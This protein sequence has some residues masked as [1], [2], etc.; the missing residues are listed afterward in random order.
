M[1][2]PKPCGPSCVLA[3]KIHLLPLSASARPDGAWIHEGV[4]VRQISTQAHE[5]SHPFALVGDEGSA[6]VRAELLDRLMQDP[7]AHVVPV[8]EVCRC[9]FSMP[10]LE[11]TP[12]QELGLGFDQDRLVHP[13]ARRVDWPA[14]TLH[15]LLAEL[16]RGL[17]E[18]R[19]SGI[20]HGDPAW[21]NAFASLG[22]D[23]VHRGLWVD[24]NSMRPG[25]P[26][27]SD[28]DVAA[29]LLT[30]LVPALLDAR[31]HSPSLFADL[32]AASRNGVDVLESVIEALEKERRDL[33]A[34]GARASLGRALAEHGSASDRQDGVGRAH[35][36]ISAHLASQVLLD[37]TRSDQNARFFRAVLT[38]ERTRNILLE[39]ERTRLHLA[40][41]GAEQQSLQRALDELRAYSAEQREAIEY[42]ARRADGA[43]EQLR[44]SEAKHRSR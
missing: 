13:S 19:A 34:D 30:T 36:R 38:A 37:Q 17:V 35:R 39:E 3:E 20:A 14:V 21:M 8:L 22:A 11:G 9:S 4:V 29:F 44:A 32:A 24:L 15:R 23:G 7:P 33:Q 40:R 41:F 5:P 2:K 26:E 43:E 16:A 10:F 42:Q 12:L 25:T 1:S 6:Y 27:A 18:L 28:L 31:E